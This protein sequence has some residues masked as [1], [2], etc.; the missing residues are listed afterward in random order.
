M[1]EDGYEGASTRDM[2][3]R[4]GVSVAAMYHHFPSKLGLLREFLDEAYDVTIAR[5]E[6]RLDGVEGPVARLESVVATLIWTHLH[7]D[8]AQRAST[9]AFREYTR[10]D[11]PDRAAIEAK[12]TAL[13]DLVAREVRAGVADGEFHTT[14]PVET[15]RA[16]IT[17]ATSLVGVHAEID[18]SLDDITALYQQFAVILARG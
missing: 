7:D 8:F 10:L 1:G 17:L 4:A 2:A 3:A 12:R 9:V 18:R 14:E 15:A 11:A 16:I 6:R 13:L 5:I